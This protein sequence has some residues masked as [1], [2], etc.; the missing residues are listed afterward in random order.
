M[1]LGNVHPASRRKGGSDRTYPTLNKCD[2]YR[3]NEA[4]KH[5][6]RFFLDCDRFHLL[7]TFFEHLGDRI[8]DEGRAIA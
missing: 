8:V 2:R 1:D 6:V 7:R 5:L 4:V 3:C